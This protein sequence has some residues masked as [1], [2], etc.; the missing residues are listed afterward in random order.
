MDQMFS[1]EAHF[2]H[3][4]VKLTIFTVG[5]IPSIRTFTSVNKCLTG[6]GATI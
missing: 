5:T 3:P 1:Y 4:Q 2:K 6:T